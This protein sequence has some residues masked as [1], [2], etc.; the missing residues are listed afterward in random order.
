MTTTHTMH[1]DFARFRCEAVTFHQR[2]HQR[3]L[4]DPASYAAVAVGEGLEAR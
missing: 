2:P 4:T 1:R 3:L